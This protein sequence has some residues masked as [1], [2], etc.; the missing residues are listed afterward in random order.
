MSVLFLS[1]G[2]GGSGV[3]M[4]GVGS[5]TVEGEGAKGAG[6]ESC[7]WLLENIRVFYVH[8]FV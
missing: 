8:V 2:G 1:G 4:V 5:S 3:E 7:G 6:D